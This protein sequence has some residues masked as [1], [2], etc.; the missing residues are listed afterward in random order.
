MSAPAAID[1]AAI[2]HESKENGVLSQGQLHVTL[3]RRFWIKIL[4]VVDD[5]IDISEDVS[6]SKSFCITTL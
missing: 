6:L 2:E 4:T 5:V 3:F 1:A